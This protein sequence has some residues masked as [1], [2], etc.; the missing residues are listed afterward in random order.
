MRNMEPDHYRWGGI[1]R[2]ADGPLLPHTS[3][4]YQDLAQGSDAVCHYR[5]IADSPI[6]YRINSEAPFSEFTYKEAEAHWKEGDILEL[7]AEYFPYAIFVH[8]DSPQKIDYWHQFVILKGKYH[9][10]EIKT[11]GCFDRLFSPK[12][13]RVETVKEA[14]TY[15]WSYFSGI[16]ED[17]RKECAY[18]NIHERNGH[19]VGFYWLEG[20]EPILSDEVYLE[21]KWHRL[22]Y[23]DKDDPTVNFTHAVW[24]FASKEI[25]CD[26]QW[27][28]KGFLDKPRLE[29]IGLSQTYGPWYEGR[30]P[31][32]HQMWFNINE[33]MG[34]TVEKILEMGF[35]ITE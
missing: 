26:C 12:E 18:A 30:A 15:I 4:H 3:I 6:T 2:L 35:E 16:R 13:K 22:S 17:G 21:A 10:E 5:K 34:M 9:G 23:T 1:V 24:R 25:H 29:T 19:G 14:T 27:G 28:S 8:T 32:K 31:Y 7:Q 20:E 33:N 11:L